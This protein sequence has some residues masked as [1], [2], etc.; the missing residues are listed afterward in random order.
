MEA[1]PCNDLVWVFDSGL[2]MS[3]WNLISNT[4]YVLCG[5]AGIFAVHFGRRGTVGT[6]LDNDDLY[7]LLAAV[8]MIGVSSSVY[9]GTLQTWSLCLDY[10]SIEVVTIIMLWFLVRSRVGERVFFLL[11]CGILGITALLIL[12][13]AWPSTH[14]TTSSARSVY[15]MF[16]AVLI[17]A[18]HASMVHRLA[19]HKRC[20]GARALLGVSVCFSIAGLSIFFAPVFSKALCHSLYGS[21]FHAHAL[22]HL[23]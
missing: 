5:L 12:L 7:I 2:R 19:G 4:A 18:L 22:W 1:N 3:K 8:I 14:V 6:L 13:T 15:Y 20:K 23:F 17:T 10:F 21:R 11:A 16:A 9:H